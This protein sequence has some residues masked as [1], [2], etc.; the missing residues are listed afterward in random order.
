MPRP[1]STLGG[2]YRAAAT[3]VLSLSAALLAPAHAAPFQGGVVTLV[4]STSAGSS[5][6]IAARALAEPLSKAWG[7]PVVVENKPGAS[8]LIASQYVA[9]AA[10]D[11]RTLLLAVTPTIQAPFLLTNAGIAPLKAFTPIIQIFDARLWLAVNTGVGASDVKGLVDVA[12]ERKDLAYSSPGAGSTP[13]LNAMQLARQAKVEM[14]HVPYRGVSP[15]VVDLAGGR[16]ASTFASY[17]DLLPHVSAGT[18][19]VL[20][21][22]GE[23]R[24]PLT[25]KVPSM[26]EQGYP[27]F[28]VIGFG[29]VVAPAGTPAERVNQLAVDIGRVVA[30]PRL[31]ERL[32]QL[33]LEPVT[34]SSPTGFGQVLDEQSAYW[35][36]IIA[37]SGVKAD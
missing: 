12:R 3:L 32:F 9:R 7:V 37:E 8:S 10:P 18:V 36:K 23:G 33:G 5:F 21:S 27:G 4:T 15:A 13:H 30:D 11:G 17:S 28:D 2:R 31:Q 24:S 6:D 16:I 26:R 14:L 19:K 20:A 29:G 34:N 25:P 1:F 22:T 35:K